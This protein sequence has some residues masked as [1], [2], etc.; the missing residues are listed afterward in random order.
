MSLNTTPPEPLPTTELE[1]EESHELRGRGFELR[2]D[3]VWS[4][5][6]ESVRLRGKHEPHSIV[7]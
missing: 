3:G 1:P 2:L 7:K 5:R 4:W 6:P